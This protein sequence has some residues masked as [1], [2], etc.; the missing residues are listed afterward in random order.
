L[1]SL[2]SQ[3]SKHVETLKLSDSGWFHP[4]VPN[5][6]CSVLVYLLSYWDVFAACTN[7]AVS[8]SL[9]GKFWHIMREICL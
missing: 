1:D 2:S 4:C 5:A 3:W 9:A 7:F 8:T 6:L